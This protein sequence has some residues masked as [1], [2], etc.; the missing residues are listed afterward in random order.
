LR[1]SV[2]DY[3]AIHNIISG[4]LYKPRHDEMSM[5][6]FRVTI[7]GSL[8]MLTGK[9]IFSYTLWD[10]NRIPAEACLRTLLSEQAIIKDVQEG[11]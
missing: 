7:S 4:V 2:L 8:I 3:T 1:D 9:K 10:W 5:V 6:H 11:R